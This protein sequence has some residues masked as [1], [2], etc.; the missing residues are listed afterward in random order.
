MFITA[1]RSIIWAF[2]LFVFNNCTHIYKLHSHTE[3][4]VSLTLL[5]ESAEGWEGGEGDGGAAVVAAAAAPPEYQ[6]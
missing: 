2:A 5:P 3:P 6:L 4:L 1:Q